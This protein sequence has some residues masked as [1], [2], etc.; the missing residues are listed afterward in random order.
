MRK[1]EAIAVYDPSDVWESA[2]QDAAKALEGNWLPAYPCQ[3]LAQSVAALKIGTDWLSRK[4][5]MPIRASYLFH[6]DFT[7]KGI[8][9]FTTHFLFLRDILENQE[10]NSNIHD[11][12]VFMTDALANF[13]FRNNPVHLYINEDLMRAANK[14]ADLLDVGGFLIARKGNIKVADGMI[15]DI[16]YHGRQN[17]ENVHKLISVIRDELGMQQTKAAASE[18]DYEIFK[19]D[20][21]FQDLRPGMTIWHKYDRCESEIVEVEPG[22]TG[23]VRFRSSSG[24]ESS[25]PKEEFNN[26]FIIT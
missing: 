3:L 7:Q 19:I 2:I 16:M 6:P 20:E 12:I 26:Q 8:R 13:L 15:T 4:E 17:Q 21:H 23:I 14:K 5:L 24:D 25:L 18:I 9:V 11:P 1:V 22:E 10:I